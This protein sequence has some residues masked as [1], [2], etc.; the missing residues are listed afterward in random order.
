MKIKDGYIIR[1]VA[2]SNIVVPVG[3]EQMS[4]GGIMTLNAVGAFVWKKLENGATK[5]ELVD[6]L[7]AEY[8]VDRQTASADIDRYIAKLREKNIIE[9]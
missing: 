2:G 1:E 3:D 9:D 7:L 4:F 5:E 8:E 6:A